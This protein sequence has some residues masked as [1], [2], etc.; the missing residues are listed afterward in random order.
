MTAAIA[1]VRRL[2]DG[3]K[4]ASNLTTIRLTIGLVMNPKLAQAHSGQVPF[5]LNAPK[6]AQLSDA[7]ATLPESRRRNR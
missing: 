4:R 3:E 5:V 6:D 1:A 2:F 7:I